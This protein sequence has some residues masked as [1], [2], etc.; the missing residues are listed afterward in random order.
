L[1]LLAPLPGRSQWQLLLLLLLHRRS[2]SCP[3]HLGSLPSLAAVSS[4]SSSSRQLGRSA[5]KCC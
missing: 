3:L 2:R 1:L 5:S 4:C